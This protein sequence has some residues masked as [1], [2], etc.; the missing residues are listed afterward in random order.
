MATVTKLYEAPLPTLEN[1]M[2]WINPRVKWGVNMLVVVKAD[3][4]F[5]GCLFIP[6]ENEIIYTAKPKLPHY[7]T[8]YNDGQWK[9]TDKPDAL[10]LECWRQFLSV[11]YNGKVL[12]EKNAFVDLKNDGVKLSEAAR[13]DIV[14]VSSSDLIKKNGKVETAKDRLQ[15]FAKLPTTSSKLKMEINGV[16][17]WLAASREVSQMEAA[18]DSVIRLAVRLTGVW[19][20]RST[21]YSAEDYMVDACGKSE[22]DIILAL[23]SGYSFIEGRFVEKG[24]RNG[25]RLVGRGSIKNKRS[26]KGA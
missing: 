11:Y 15:E 6:A 19:E 13:N 12:G 1:L 10:L 8:P 16:L 4:K 25:L 26:G 18:R 22:N 23:D 9:T 14:N 20:T 24:G 5:D 2:R 3:G 17:K 21:S 7:L